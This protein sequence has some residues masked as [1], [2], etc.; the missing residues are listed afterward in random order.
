MEFVRNLNDSAGT[1]VTAA[2]HTADFTSEIIPVSGCDRFGF[3][4]IITPVSGTT[5]TLD[6]ELQTSF[7]NGSVWI[8]FYPSDLNSQ[9][10]ASFTQITAASTGVS[11]YYDRYVPRLKPGRNPG[12]AGAAEQPIPVVRLNFDTGGTSPSFTF[13][14]AKLVLINYDTN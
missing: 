12:N 1:L 3:W 4:F 6:I 2:A 14:L 9:T 7:D 13:T 10:T 8:P 5:P 11:K